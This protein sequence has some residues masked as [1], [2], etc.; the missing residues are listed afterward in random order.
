MHV[1]DYPLISFKYSRRVGQGYKS[2]NRL[3]G[4]TSVIKS[5]HTIIG[6]A[7]ALTVECPGGQ[8]DRPNSPFTDLASNRLLRPVEH[9]T[10][11]TRVDDL[12]QGSS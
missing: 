10:R 4:S 7:V 11:G 9:L 1:F 3:A 5:I 6:L 12:L 2:L 8:A